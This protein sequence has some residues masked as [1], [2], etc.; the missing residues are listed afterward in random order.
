MKRIAAL[1]L[2]VVMMLTFV[3]CGTK[4]DKPITELTTVPSIE[5]TVPS[6]DPTEP[7]QPKAVSV[8]LTF[9]GQTFEDLDAIIAQLEADGRMEEEGLDIALEGLSRPLTLHTSY[10]K[11]T[12]YTVSGAF[13]A[14]PEEEQYYTYLSGIDAFSDLFQYG[15][16]IVLNIGDWDVTY[17]LIITPNSSWTAYPNNGR[18]LMVYQDTEGNLI[19]KERSTKFDSA[20]LEQW[21]YTPLERAHGRN[22]FF[23]A[24]G[25]CT[26]EGDTVTTHLTNEVTISDEYDLDTLFDQAKDAGMY[27]EFDTLDQLLAHNA[28]KHRPAQPK[29]ESLPLI[30]QDR[31]YDTL[32]DLMAHLEA[33]GRLENSGNEIT[34]EGL[35]TP[36]T[37]YLDGNTLMGYGVYGY[38]FDVEQEALPYTN[39]TGNVTTDLYQYDESL[40]LN[41][42]YYDAGYTLIM[43]PDGGWIHY[44]FEGRSLMVYRN[45]NGDMVC[46]QVATKFNAAI[47]QWDTAPLDLATSRDDFFYA[48]GTV[49]IDG[50]HVN[51]YLGQEVTISDVYNLDAMFTDAKSRGYY[52]EFDTLDQL[53]EQNWQEQ[54]IFGEEI[55]EEFFEEDDH[56][57]DCGDE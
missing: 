43:S 41:I 33:E 46:S 29:A 51:Y 7:E 26:I 24:T 4:G 19:A 45:D 56:Y 47:N 31:A 34:I 16:A 27:P 30:F 25:T 18:C 50:N 2:T 40:V 12:G 15:D 57:C 6:V 49:I 23:Y 54:H 10:G 42:W 20:T 8:P 37:F 13:F 53:L 36:V 5:A 55:P 21:E 17:T 14:I 44:P 22:D 38:Y 52:P 3:A 11:I 39:L 28:Q 1:L 9:E 32:D 48:T 35:I